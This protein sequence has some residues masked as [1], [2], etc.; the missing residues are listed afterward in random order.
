MLMPSSGSMT[1]LSASVTSSGDKSDANPRGAQCRL[2]FEL[3]GHD[4]PQ[5]VDGV[6]DLR[7]AQRV[8]D[9]VALALGF[10]QA[11]VAQDG[12]VLGGVGLRSLDDL[13]EL[14]H[15]EGAVAQGIEEQEALGIV[16]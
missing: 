11:S 7:V 1:A 5:H 12:Q 16:Q 10:H 6:D 14:G 8:D 9:V 3:V 4:V 2:P 13:A 15:G